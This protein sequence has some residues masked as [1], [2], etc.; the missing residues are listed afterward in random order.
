MKYTNKRDTSTGYVSA[1]IN[2]DYDI[3]KKGDI[4][5]DQGLTILVIEDFNIGVDVDWNEKDRRYEGS[6]MRT[7][8]SDALPV[9]YGNVKIP[10]YTESGQ[11]SWRKGEYLKKA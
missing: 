8:D 6:T 9:F 1:S 4:L 11:W 10:G 3:P 2:V 7:N 5:C